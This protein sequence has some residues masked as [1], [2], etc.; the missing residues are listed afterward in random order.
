[1]RE[2]SKHEFSK[3]THHKVCPKNSKIR[4]ASE[5]TVFVNKEA[6]QNLAANRAGIANKTIEKSQK[7]VSWTYQGLFFAQRTNQVTPISTAMSIANPMHL[8]GKPDKRM[9]KLEAPCLLTC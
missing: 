9:K 1:M 4:G 3:R 8:C 7:N 2:E 5:R 6:D